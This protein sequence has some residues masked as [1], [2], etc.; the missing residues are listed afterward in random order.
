TRGRGPAGPTS[1]FAAAGAT[2]GVTGAA[3]FLALSPRGRGG[4]QTGLVS[5]AGAADQFADPD[6]TAGGSRA[7]RP[8]SSA[9]FSPP[10]NRASPSPT[11]F[12]RFRFIPAS[13]RV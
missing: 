11:A 7:G 12:T 3:S 1:S 5:P 4:S 13:R 6:R 10:A 8:P 9:A 2:G